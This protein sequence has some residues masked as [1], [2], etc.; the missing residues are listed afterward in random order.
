MKK[1][2]YFFLKLLFVFAILFDIN[3]KFLPSVTTSRI[4]L[5]LICLF[6][7]ARK[8]KLS[9]FCIYY[10]VVL[11]SVLVFSII[12]FLYSAD[13]TQS[14]RIIWFSLYGIVIPF[15]FKNYIK[16]RNEFFCLISVAVLIQAI[17]T[18]C[19]YLMPSI[20]AVFSSLIIYTSNFDETNLLRAMG[21][22]SVG[23][24][25]F[26]VIQSTGVISLLILNKLND[27]SFLHR[28]LLW[29]S[30][31]VIFVSIF[32]IGRTG[33]FISII[34]TFIYI[35]SLQLK[36]KNIAVVVMFLFL[37]FQIN[38]I[39]LID[40]LTSNID[41]FKSELFVNWIENSFK[42]K[43]NETASD[44]NEMPIPPLSFETI[45]G[46]GRV[47]DI[48][49]F[50]NASGHD[51]GYVQTYYSLGL[52]LAVFFYSAFFVFLIYQIKIQNQ[53]KTEKQTFLYLLVFVVFIVEFKEPFIFSYSFPF[54][55]LTSIL[56]YSKQDNNLKLNNRKEIF[57][58]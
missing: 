12:Q 38:Y 48:S 23:G 10:L 20:K 47:L 58:V 37:A 35:L 49:G 14:S 7:F 15:L 27:L 36:L 44:L 11:F 52:L 21:F 54:F 9:I 43:G 56:V 3:F 42:L 41:G 26:S 6:A 19:S 4:A 5:I 29:V 16:N 55:V 24:A 45:I 2:F 40:N 53:F 22:A 13:F 17:L 39:N 50:G 8:N 32:F 18:I 1:K 46:T 34:A 30:I 25:S 28:F 57:V 31:L 33:L 51:S